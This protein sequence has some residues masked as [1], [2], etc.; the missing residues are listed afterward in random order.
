MARARHSEFAARVRRQRASRDV[1]QATAARRPDRA[2]VRARRVPPPT[3]DAD[4]AALRPSELR[5]GYRRS[6]LATPLEQVWLQSSCSIGHS[7][8]T[9]SRCVPRARTASRARVCWRDLR[10]GLAQHHVQR[11][12]HNAK[13]SGAEGDH[14]PGHLTPESSPLLT[15]SRC[16]SRAMPVA[17]ARITPGVHRRGAR[18][19]ASCS[20]SRDQHKRA[21]GLERAAD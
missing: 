16:A 14:A 11:A 17:A 21:L 18:P 12:E 9:G 6:H 20:R 8:S 13:P 15:L 3:R 2:R 7:I 4:P 5:D 1:A 10:A 19:R